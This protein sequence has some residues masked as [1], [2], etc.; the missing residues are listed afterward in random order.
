MIE[1]R[2][3]AV[4]GRTFAIM[5][6]MGYAVGAV[7]TREGVGELTSPLAG[8]AVALLAGALAMGVITGR[9]FEGGF[10][11]KKSSVLFFLLAGLASGSGALSSFFALSMAPVVIVSPIQNTY[12]LFAL[13]FARI[14]LARLER[15]TLR[16]VLGA[17][18]VVGGVVLITLGKAG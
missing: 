13:L 9:R 17:V 2:R 11:K 4:I 15:I 5:S 7:L 14:F 10:R 6:A 12:P 1:K 18:F 3:D 16:L 8:S